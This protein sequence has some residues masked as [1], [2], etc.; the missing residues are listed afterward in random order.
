MSYLWHTRQGIHFDTGR[1]AMAEVQI[2]GRSI[3]LLKQ[4]IA[5]LTD[6]VLIPDPLSPGIRD[7]E[8]VQ[9]T[10]RALLKPGRR[11]KKIS[12]SLSD[13]SARVTLIPMEKPIS[14]RTEVEKLIQWKMEKSSLYQPEK[15][16]LRYQ[17]LSSLLLAS[18]IYEPVLGQYEAVLHASGLEPRLIDIA[19]FHVFNL[20]HDYLLHHSA[21]R[22]CFVFLYAGDSFFTVMIFL[23]GVL[24]FIR[25]KALRSQTRSTAEKVIE[26]LRSS[27]EF[28]N[29]DHDI[30]GL[31]HLFL[32]GLPVSEMLSKSLGDSFAWEI[33]QLKPE[34]VFSIAPQS[35]EIQ[36]ED[37]PA[38]IPAIAAAV[39]R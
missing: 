26:E 18:T 16:R 39:G 6:R 33:V 17:L 9:K 15:L 34:N 19:S 20:Y 11:S 7:E 27:L 14:Q 21:P 22:H 28:Y 24:N 13:L 5:Y 23:R 36:V 25:I 30:T 10:L 3:K 1:I 37:W 12:V 38:L 35:G 4:E 8:L 29:E 2:R 31:T 32:A